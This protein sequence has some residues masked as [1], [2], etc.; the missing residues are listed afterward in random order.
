[1]TNSLHALL[2]P[3]TGEQRESGKIMTIKTLDARSRDCGAQKNNG[4]ADPLPF[5]FVDSM[6]LPT[7]VTCR[8]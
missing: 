2:C 3:F 8:D 1:M 4:R 5:Y 6:L 7:R